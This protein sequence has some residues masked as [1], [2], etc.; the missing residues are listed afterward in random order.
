M[1]AAGE[2][3]APSQEDSTAAHFPWV[4]RQDTDLERF[5]SVHAVREALFSD[6]H[7]TLFRRIEELCRPEDA[8]DE[9][10]T[11]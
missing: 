3:D 7:R 11:E 6:H 9:E 1:Y 10:A 2:D 8:D 4:I 5:S